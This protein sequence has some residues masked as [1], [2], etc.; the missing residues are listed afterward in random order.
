MVVLTEVTWG[1][2]FTIAW[3]MLRKATQR[4]AQGGR[5]RRVRYDSTRGVSS[6][7]TEREYMRQHGGTLELRYVRACLKCVCA[8]ACAR[9]CVSA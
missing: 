3:R 7:V 1:A 9:V 5:K 2:L 4:D 8:C 6:F